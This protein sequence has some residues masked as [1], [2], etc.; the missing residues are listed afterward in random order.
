L[1]APNH[2]FGAVVFR[3]EIWTIGGRRDE[4]ILD[5]VWIYNPAEGRW[6]SGPPLPEPMELVAAAVAGDQIHAVWESAYQIYD[7]RTGDWS[8]GPRPLVTRHGAKAFVVAGALYTIGG[9]TTDLHDTQ[10][11]ER[12]RLG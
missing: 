12:R 10:V 11:V 1:P 3:G 4:E 6:R 9:C 2:T 7:A 5:E 8:S